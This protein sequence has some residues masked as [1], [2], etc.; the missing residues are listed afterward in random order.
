[1]CVPNTIST[2]PL[3]WNEIKS[4]ALAFSQRWADAR[5]EDS[6][7][8]PFWIDFFDLFGI[9]DKR[10]A[11]FE[12]AVRRLPGARA[13]TDGFIDLFWPG[14]LLVEHKSR[15]KDLDQAMEQAISYLP[16]IAE[17]DL[18]QILIV[19]DFARFRVRQLASGETREFALQDLHKHIKLFGFM[20]GY[21]TQTIAPQDCRP[22]AAATCWGIR[23]LWAPSSW[24]MRSA[25][26]RVPCSRAS[27]TLASWISS[28][29]G[30]SRPLPICK[31]RPPVVVPSSRPIASR[32]APAALSAL[33]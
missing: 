24:M 4:K 22:G 12:H 6:E 19:C 29:P 16:G 26:R 9:T 10:V 5:S 2:M 14:M 18:P 25:K 7:A 11:T 27:T 13:R 23:R 8:K 28:R 3:S 30:T 21:K 1:M 20:A 31:P 32:K 17:R 33:C 15:G